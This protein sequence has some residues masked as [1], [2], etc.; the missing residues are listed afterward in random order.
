[1]SEQNPN[2]GGTG[3]SAISKNVPPNVSVT[4]PD[5][6]PDSSFLPGPTFLPGSPAGREAQPV[7]KEGTGKVPVILS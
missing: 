7:L 2:L 4:S 1:M 6:T 3:D 5:H